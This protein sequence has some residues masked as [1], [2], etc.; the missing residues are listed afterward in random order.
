MSNIPLIL[1]FFLPFTFHIIFTSASKCKITN[2]HYTENLCTT[3]SCSAEFKDAGRDTFTLGPNENQEPCFWSITHYANFSAIRNSKYGGNIYTG[4]D[5]TN[6]NFQNRRVFGRTIKGCSEAEC[7]WIFEEVS[8]QEEF[9]TI[10]NVGHDEYLY[11]T[12]TRGRF[13]RRWTY[14][15]IDSDYNPENDTRAHWSI[16]CE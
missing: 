10:K 15:R 8:G 7:Y 13:N 6:A 3:C 4:D 1:I 12:D 14:T 5:N 9:S 16:E 2:R 11:A